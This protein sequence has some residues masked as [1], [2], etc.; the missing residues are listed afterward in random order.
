VMALWPLSREFFFAD[1][2]VF[3]AISRRYWLP[4]FITHNVL[5][6]AREVAILL[7]IA[8]GVWWVRRSRVEAA[9]ERLPT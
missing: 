6:V 5:A 2:F 7:P 3:E 9:S 8:V 1:A 4:G